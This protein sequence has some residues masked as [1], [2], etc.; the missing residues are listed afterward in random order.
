MKNLNDRRLSC[1]NKTAVTVSTGIAVVV[2]SGSF[3]IGDAVIKGPH[4]DGKV[5]LEGF[6]FCHKCMTARAETSRQ[7]KD[8]VCFIVVIV[9]A[10][11]FLSG[12]VRM[13][14]HGSF[15]GE[16]GHSEGGEDHAH[17]KAQGYELINGLFPVFL[18]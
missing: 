13:E 4:S 12:L 11:G 9:C 6:R 2:N 17:S 18:L 7:Y 16:G 10:C 15:C 8:A 1:F 14:M 3:V 5:F